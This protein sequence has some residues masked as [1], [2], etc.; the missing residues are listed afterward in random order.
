[1]TE[2]TKEMIDWAS[3]YVWQN[4]YTG[5]RSTLRSPLVDWLAA[6]LMAYEEALSARTEQPDCTP[7]PDSQEQADRIAELEKELETAVAFNGDAV[8][9]MK[10]YRA[11]IKVREAEIERLKAERDHH[12]RLKEMHQRDAESLREESDRNAVLY[13]ER[14]AKIQQLKADNARMRKALES[15]EEALAKANELISY[16]RG[17]INILEGG[18]LP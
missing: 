2:P 10:D 4:G 12:R 18:A 1:M 9:A 13:A 7:K 3:E 6:A 8:A 14:G 17:E 16:L 15:S 5:K 11:A